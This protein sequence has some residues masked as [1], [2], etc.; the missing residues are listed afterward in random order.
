MLK[1]A[2]ILTSVLIMCLAA[3]VQPG[4]AAAQQVIRIGGLI[5][6]DPNNFNDLGREKVIEHVVSSFNAEQAA[7]DSGYMIEYTRVPVSFNEAGLSHEEQQI[8]KAVGDA[9][10]S[11]IKYF[12]GPSASSSALTA[13][14]FTDTTPDAVLISASST[15]PSLAIPGDSLFRLTHDD[16]AQAPKLAE[17]MERD[18]KDHVVFVQRE[19]IWGEGLYNAISNVY[20]G[21]EAL[22]TMAPAG[23]TASG[24]PSYYDGIAAQLRDRVAAFSALHGSENVAVVLV[25]FDSDTANLVEAVL[26]NGSADILAKVKWYGTDGLAGNSGLAANEPVASFLSTVR[27][28]STIFKVGENPTNLQLERSLE[29]YSDLDLAYGDSVYDATYLLADS[30]IAAREMS[31]RDHVVLV[32][33]LVLSVADGSAGHDYSADRSPGD[34][35]LGAYTLNAAGDLSEPDTYDL[36]KLVEGA[37][38]SHEW[39]SA[40]IHACR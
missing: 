34:G 3:V 13:K 20:G 33:D 36:L 25:L 12:V 7:L 10:R 11:G 40:P 31:T 9:Y 16:R 23:S 15:A 29:R 17:L 26:A 19:D 2:A 27:L 14:M 1:A 21:D 28:V 18:G 5:L 6:D 30:V 37:G 38:G 4:D 24:A 39:I 32:R 35:A 22:I 8:Y